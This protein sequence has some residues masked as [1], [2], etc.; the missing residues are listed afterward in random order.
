MARPAY[1]A[2][3]APMVFEAQ[4]NADQTEIILV[5][6]RAA[7]DETRDGFSVYTGVQIPAPL[8]KFGVEYNYG[9]RYWM[10]FTQAQDDVVG[11]K[12]ATR[13]HAGEAYYIFD[14]NPNM[15]IKIGGIYYDYEYSNSGTPVGKPEKISD[16]EDGKAFSMLPAVDEVWDGYASL[17][18]KFSKSKAV[19]HGE[20]RISP[21]P[22]SVKNIH[23]FALIE[24]DGRVTPT[25]E[26]T[27]PPPLPGSFLLRIGRGGGRVAG[28]GPAGAGQDG[29]SRRIDHPAG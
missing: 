26:K 13:G 29:R 6:A 9:S 10:P 18:V 25:R 15:F 3:W 7:E 27:E 24:G 21:L 11:S 2:A 20:R 12:L 19:I 22:F 28:Q 8:G 5:P 1:S 14:I 16:I 4:L 17:T 23:L